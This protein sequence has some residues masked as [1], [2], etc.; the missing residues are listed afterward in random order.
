MTKNTVNDFSPP[1]NYTRQES[2]GY[3]Y[4]EGKSETPCEQA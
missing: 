3:G 4:T 1:Y 2:A